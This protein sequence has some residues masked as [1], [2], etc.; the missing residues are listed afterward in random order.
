MSTIKLLS[1]AVTPL[2]ETAYCEVL[3]QAE[4]GGLYPVGQS[5]LLAVLPDDGELVVN[6]KDTVPALG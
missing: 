6:S 3:K 2:G 5:V 4:L 1:A